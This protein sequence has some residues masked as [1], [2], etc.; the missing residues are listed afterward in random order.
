MSLALSHTTFDALDPYRVAE[1][2]RQ[3][4]GWEI[5]EP[6]CYEPGSDECYLRGPRSDVLLFYR[7]PDAKKIK[8][9]AH[10]D[11]VPENSTKDEEVERALELGAVMVDDR[12]GDL[13]WAVMA[14]PEGNEFC[15]LT[16]PG[17]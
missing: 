1:F 17:A 8:N 5:H 9:R 13:G 4:I 3:L 15:I 2:W 14:D 6:D 12:R 11:L 7:V 10:L 16:G